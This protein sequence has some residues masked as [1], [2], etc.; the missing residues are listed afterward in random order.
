VGFSAP[1]TEPQKE[2]LVGGGWDQFPGDAIPDDD[3]DD[4]EFLKS[5]EAEIKKKA[6]RTTTRGKR[7]KRHKPHQAPT[8]EGD[9]TE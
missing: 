5:M 6:E 8:E 2:A 9:N 4:E 7:N 1:N 3:D